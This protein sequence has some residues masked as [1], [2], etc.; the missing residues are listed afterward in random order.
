MEYEKKQKDRQMDRQTNR[1]CEISVAAMTGEPE[2]R[3]RD[4]H[5]AKCH[6]DHLKVKDKHTQSGWEQ[7]RRLKILVLNRCGNQS[8]MNEKL[9]PL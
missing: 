2:A 9:D 4:I 6:S 5:L 3:A 7:C 1:K 8:L